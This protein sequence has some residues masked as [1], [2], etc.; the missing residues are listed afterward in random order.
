M[1]SRI[2]IKCLADKCKLDSVINLS[3]MQIQLGIFCRKSPV[4][5]YII[6]P[7]LLHGNLLKGRDNVSLNREAN[8]DPGT[9]SLCMQFENH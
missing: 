9:E 4:H 5:F 1:Y 2:I 8:L 3:H 7:P 6:R